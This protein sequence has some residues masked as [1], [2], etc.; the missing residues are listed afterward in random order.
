M[1]RTLQELDEVV[2]RLTAEIE[3]LKRAQ[4]VTNG[5]ESHP[6]DRHA[7]RFTDDED[8]LSMMDEIQRARREQAASENA[9]S[10][11]VAA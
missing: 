3:D 8:W 2:N 1:A 6:F 11:L 5:A 4:S 7:G 10:D 9:E